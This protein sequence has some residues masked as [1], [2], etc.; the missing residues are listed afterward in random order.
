MV[1]WSTLSL[2]GNQLSIANF[3]LL[4]G[5]N[6]YEN[7][8]IIDGTAY[9]ALKGDTAVLCLLLTPCKAVC[10][11]RFEHQTFTYHLS[12]SIIRAVISFL[13]D[14]PSFQT[15]V[16]R[17]FVYNSNPLSLP[18]KLSRPLSSEPISSSTVLAASLAKSVK[19]TISNL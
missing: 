12:C 5:C 15:L 14:L 11:L 8:L 6:T 17:F 2:D 18:F 10:H 1:N 9:L 4:P 3:E 16:S 7:L 19:L 13:S